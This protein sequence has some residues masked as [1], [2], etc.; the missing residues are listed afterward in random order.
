MKKTEVE[1]FEIAYG[2]AGVVI[3]STGEVYTFFTKDLSG[4]DIEP[5]EAVQASLVFAAASF[6]N[7]PKARE[8]A[9][10]CVEEEIKKR[11]E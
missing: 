7:S 2:D 5:E 8:T 11:S 1:N 10:K 4:Q 9:K 6:V 3:T